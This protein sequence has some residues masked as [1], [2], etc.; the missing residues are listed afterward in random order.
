MTLKRKLRTI[1]YVLIAVAALYLLLILAQ[2]RHG[3]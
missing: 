2:S 3:G 1:G